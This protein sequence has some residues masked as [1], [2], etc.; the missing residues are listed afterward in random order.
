MIFASKFEG[1][2]LPILEAFDASLPVLSSS[3]STLPEVA[4]DGALYFGPDSP[5]ELA[6]LMKLILDLPQM[7]E[8]LTR[9]GALVLSQHSIDKT[10]AGFRELYKKTAELSRRQHSTVSA[11]S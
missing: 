9:K 2:G 3:A 4:G 11:E 10:A 6:L 1:F 8:D 7:R 5:A